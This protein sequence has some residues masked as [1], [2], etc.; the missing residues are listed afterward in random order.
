MDFKWEN[1]YGVIDQ[2]FFKK[3]NVSDFYKRLSKEKISLKTLQQI[4][5]VLVVPV[6]FSKRRFYDKY[7]NHN[8]QNLIRYLHVDGSYSLHD[9]LWLIHLYIKNMNDN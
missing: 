7:L 6:N 4:E 8:I 1:D 9:L 3:S 5:K 2:S